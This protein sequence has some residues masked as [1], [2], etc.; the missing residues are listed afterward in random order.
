MTKVAELAYIDLPDEVLARFADEDAAAAAI[1]TALV[2]ARR[3]CGWHVSPVR[4]NDK[5]IDI[6]GPGGPVLSL[7][8]LNLISVSAVTELGVAVNVATL[9]RSRRTGTLTKQS[10]CW[11]AR[12]GA[13][14]AT[15]THGFTEAEAADWRAAIV[16]LVDLMSQQV[17]TIRAG[18]DMIVKKVDDVEYRWSDRTVTID[19]RLSALF[20]PYWILPPP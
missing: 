7:P 6:D 10:G 19:E 9:D 1:N 18:V 3:F 5:L 13:I 11:T 2:T 20:A 17:A 16:S 12:A 4:T 15:I 8:T 14:T